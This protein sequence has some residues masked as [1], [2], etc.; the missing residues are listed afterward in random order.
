MPNSA[1][2]NWKLLQNIASLVSGRVFVSMSRLLIVLIIVRV[3][4]TEVLG[5]YVVVMSILYIGEWLMDFGF[6]DIAVRNIAQSHDKRKAIL[7]AFSLIKLLQAVLAFGA[8]ILAINLLGYPELATAVYIGGA[9]I[10]FYGGAQIYRV[11]CRVDMTMHKDMMSES[12]GVLV[13]L[14]LALLL[15]LGE[16]N[17]TAF[18]ACYTISRFIYFAVN[19]VLGSR[20]Y[21]P[22]LKADY[23][24]DVNLLLRQAGPLGVAGITVA[25][26]DALIPLVLSKMVSMEAVAIYTVAIRLVFPIIMVTHA[27]VNVFYTPLSNYFHTDK[28]LFAVTQQNVVE[29]IVL[30]SS[31]F[32]CLVYSSSD[33]IVSFFGESMDESARILRALSWAI[34]ARALSI[35][36]ASPIIICGGQRK[37]MWITVMVVISSAFLVSYLVPIYGINGAVGTYLF[38]ELV[39]TAVPVIYLSLRMADYSLSWLPVLKLFLAAVTAVAVVSF[40]P[41]NGSLVGG[42][43]SLIIF[44][45][46]TFLVGG[47]SKEKLESV[48]ALVKNRSAAKS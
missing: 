10:V 23:K 35:A 36:M 42:I 13:M 19:L 20:V 18:V 47:V 2:S 21:R 16:P 39:V 41:I 25:C 1:N 5:Q 43:V 6:T 9:G 8:V 29:I 14:I 22:K 31:F 28:K 32:F 44:V 40:L 17:V 15:A 7:D 37:T 38:V 4:G 45:L 3:A 30:V 27:I 34:L 26:Y 11:S 46:V 48:I 12:T 33:F 24:G